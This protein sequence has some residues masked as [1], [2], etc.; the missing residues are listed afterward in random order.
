MIELARVIAG[1]VSTVRQLRY[2]DIVLSITA[3]HAPETA[4]I[5]IIIE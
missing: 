5:V 2:K 1:I 3:L 4:T